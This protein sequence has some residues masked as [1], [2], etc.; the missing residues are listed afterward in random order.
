M[1]NVGFMPELHGLRGIAAISVLLFHWVTIFPGFGQSLIPYHVPGHPWLNPSLP[2]AMGWQGV[3]LFFVLSGYLLTS[4]L[5]N[6]PLTWQVV[7]LFYLRRVL[8]IYP[9]V[10][11]QLAV[12]LMLG[13]WFP[14]VFVSQPWDRTLLN[15]MLWINLPPVYA[16]ML[17]DVWWT[18]PVELLFYA[19]LPLLLVLRKNIGLGLVAALMLFITFGWRAWVM[20]VYAGQ[21]LSA[22]QYVLDA[23]PGVLTSFGSG[24]MAAT[25]QQR[26]QSKNGFLLLA[27]SVFVFLLLQTWLVS[28]IETYW[29]GGL[30]LMVWN[31]LLSLSMSGIVLAICHGGL[32]TT[33]KLLSARPMVLLGEWSF[34]IYL[35][36]YPVM[37]G[38]KALWPRSVD[39]H[40]ESLLALGVS[41]AIA[42]ALAALSFHVVE[43]R[44]MDMAT[45]WVR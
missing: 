7:R 40:V 37:M 19:S 26:V 29:Q 30:L 32:D 41:V 2:F 27:V 21:N 36:H 38:L 42:L 17:N 18:L 35:W 15:A 25:L 5:H 23:L 8:R 28:G 13:W 9:A 31:T 20:S 33:Q 24:F 12:L 11:M 22:H 34:G 4:H 1:K 44:M 6:K 43:K 3:T 45:D 14:L 39:Q 10:W 16:P